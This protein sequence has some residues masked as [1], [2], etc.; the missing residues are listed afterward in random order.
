[1]IITGDELPANAAALWWSGKAAVVSTRPLPTA[2]ETT[3]ILIGDGWSAFVRTSQTVVDPPTADVV[4]DDASAVTRAIAL[5][6][7]SSPLA[8]RAAPRITAAEPIVQ[9]EKAYAEMSA[10]DASYRL[11]ALFRLWSVIDRFYPYKALIGDW[12]GVLREFIP[13][14][15]AAEGADAYARTV[16][17]L[18]ARIEDG[19][20]QVTGPAA[21]WDVIGP[22]LLP[23]EVRPVEGRFI[24][25]AK[26]GALPPDADIAVGD[27][28]LSVDG[29][30]LPDRIQRLWKYF[31][32]S[33]EAARLATVAN[34]ALRGP[35]D[36]TAELVVRGANGKPRTV[37]I[38]RVR[39]SPT[40][41]VRP[42]W[43]ILDHGIG[44]IDL[45]RLMPDQIDAAF[46]AVK[47][48]KALIFDMRGYPNGTGWSI[49]SRI[50][51]K[52]ATVGALFSRP[53]ISVATFD[54]SNTR[55]AFEQRF[56][57]TDKPKYV[58][59]TAML[60]DDRALSQ[61]EQ[62]GLWFEAASGTKF[63]GTNTAGADGDTTTTVLP[64]G[65]YVGFTG[66]EV[67]HADG[68]QLQRIGLVPDIRVTPTVRGIRAG[69]DEVLDRAVAYL[70]K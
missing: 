28:I 50:N 32:A 18:A 55:Y 12:D 61:A 29:E 30:P 60:I 3:Q 22:R 35:R 41:D 56:E 19:H 25:A 9:M 54:Q 57:T 8:T 20:T 64:G 47:N 24:V 37:K 4:A 14:F 15:E 31:T 42:V 10:P 38:A 39:T 5:A 36:S 13:R 11:L 66:H 23:I 53:E 65:I 52:N 6:H 46:D 49:A 16:M 33:T 59:R 7:D 17:E 67:R 68:R 21:V 43:R 34:F 1:V 2:G 45:T 26:R 40:V 44:Y 63:I 69:R 62:T 58:G 70:T 48:T 27:E 51:R